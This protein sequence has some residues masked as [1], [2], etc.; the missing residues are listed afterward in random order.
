MSYT[1]PVVIIATIG[2]C[3]IGQVLVDEDNTL[4]LLY[5]NH[6]SGIE[7]KDEVIVKDVRDLAMFNRSTLQPYR[8]IMLDIT[9]HNKVLF[10]DFYLIQ[11]NSHHNIF[12]D[13]DWTYQIG[14]IISMFYRFLKFPE[15][16]MVCKV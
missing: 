6:W 7:L 5:L 3:R 12:L 9:L 14:A 15:G 10:K 1:D 4:S 11:H 2:D 16:D 8:K 13:K